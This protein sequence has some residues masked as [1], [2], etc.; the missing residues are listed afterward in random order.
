MSS[1]V[2][3]LNRLLLFEYTDSSMTDLQSQLNL[4]QMIKNHLADIARIRE[5]LRSQKEM[6]KQSFEQDKEYNDADVE[7]KTLTR[8]R[9]E[10]KQRIV[11]TDAVSAVQSTIK[12]L[13]EELK[14][15]QQAVS[16]YLNQYVMQTQ[17]TE[18]TGPDGE[19]ALS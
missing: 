3:V 11:K 2:W 18:F 15:A 14:D 5:K 17:A 9:T 16:D 19:P 1:T 6:F 10:A 12:Q 8:K 4:E 13:Q 7:H